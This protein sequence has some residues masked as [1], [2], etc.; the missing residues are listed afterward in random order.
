MKFIARGNA[1]RVK[2]KSAGSSQISRVH[3]ACRTCLRAVAG[4]EVLLLLRA[5]AP[6]DAGAH[7]EEGTIRH[8]YDGVGRLG[9]WVA[10][11]V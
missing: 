3:R 4:Q 1:A 11:V 5:L 8:V 9:R 6:G 10:H 7:D 2:A